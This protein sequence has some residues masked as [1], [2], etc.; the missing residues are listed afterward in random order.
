[1]DK[2]CSDLR[3]RLPKNILLA[4]ATQTG[5]TVFISQ[6][7]KQ[8]G[9]VFSPE[10]KHV[11]YCYGAWQKIYDDLQTSLGDRIVFRQDIPSKEELIEASERAKKE[12]II[13]VLDDKISSFSE[14]KRGTEILENVCVTAHHYNVTC[15]VAIQ[16]LYHNKIIREISLN[17]HFLIL[18]RNAR[19]YGQIR[20]LASQIM[21]ANIDYFTSSYEM[22]TSQMYGY[23]LIDLSPTCD[24]QYQLRTN[25]FDGQDTIIF[26]P[27]K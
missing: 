2:G 11:I 13:L 21:P 23:L 24:R 6:L 19:N 8:N 14:N 26:T 18:F 20:I 3:I 27:R 22:A 7:L 16:N 15:I 5:K 9:A 10:Y 4:G 17:S 25:I 12:H 1:M